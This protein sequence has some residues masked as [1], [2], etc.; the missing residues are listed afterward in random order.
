MA[1]QSYRFLFLGLVECV[2]LTPDDRNGE[3]AIREKVGNCGE[4]VL[5]L[6]EL[7]GKARNQEAAYQTLNA[8]YAKGEPMSLPKGV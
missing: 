2:R 1:P 6:R 3:Q 5:L 7:G 4:Q 8:S